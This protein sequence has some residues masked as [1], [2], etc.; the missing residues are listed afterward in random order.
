LISQLEGI[1]FAV[2]PSFELPFAD[3]KRRN[4]QKAH[5]KWTGRNGTRKETKQK[6]ARQHEGETREKGK[7][8]GEDRDS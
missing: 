5:G 8:V 2:S 7:F 4:G 3:Q 1:R 6:K